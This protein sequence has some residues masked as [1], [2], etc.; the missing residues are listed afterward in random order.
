MA[1]K[2]GMKASLNPQLTHWVFSKNTTWPQ[3]LQ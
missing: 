3:W 2:S 1:L